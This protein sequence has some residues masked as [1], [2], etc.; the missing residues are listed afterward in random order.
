LGENHG[1]PAAGENLTIWVVDHS[2][3]G[4]YSK[5][6]TGK[7][8]HPHALLWGD[9]GEHR[10]PQLAARK[11]RGV[12]IGVRSHKIRGERPLTSNP[13]G[14]CT[15][16]G[17]KKSQEERINQHNAGQKKI[18]SFESG[19]GRCARK[20]EKV[21]GPQSRLGRT[22]PINS[23][24]HHFCRNHGTA[25]Q[26]GG[27]QKK[28]RRNGGEK[29]R[30]KNPSNPGASRISTSKQFPDW[31]R[32]ESQQVKNKPLERQKPGRPDKTS[33]DPQNNLTSPGTN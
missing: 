8:F 14:N 11:R 23:P 13:T 24:R 29:K 12:T 7:R 18:R 17:E 9:T 26:K 31:S 30:D 15:F 21:K 32:T 16:P 27:G 25:Q 19:R 22:F 4:N 33:P 1:S 20:E 3:G 28:T 2:R 10:R 5:V 6:N